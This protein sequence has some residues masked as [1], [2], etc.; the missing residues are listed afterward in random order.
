MGGGQDPVFGDQGA[1]TGVS[2]VPAGSLVLK[3]DL[4][5]PTV[6]SYIY[7]INYPGNAGWYSWHATAVGYKEKQNII[8]VVKFNLFQFKLKNMTKNYFYKCLISS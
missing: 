3:G 2:P 8:Q 7:A 4:P 5:W 6:W 1:T